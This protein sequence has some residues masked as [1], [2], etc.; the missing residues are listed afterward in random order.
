MR[1]IYTL[2]AMLFFV[3]FTFAQVNQIQ[4]IEEGPSAPLHKINRSFDSK[5]PTDTINLEDFFNAGQPSMGGINGMFGWMFGSCWWGVDSLA[6]NACAQGF[7]VTPGNTYNLEEVLIWAHSKYNVST[8][9]SSLIVTINAIDATQTYTNS[10]GSNTIDCPGT[11]LGSA[12]IPF[13][14]IDTGLSLAF[15]TASFSPSIPMTADYAIVVD[16]SDFYLNDDTVGFVAGASGSASNL[17]GIEYT[18]WKYHNTTSSNDFWTQ[19]SHVFTTSGSPSDRAIAFWPVVDD[20]TAGIDAH[21][22]VE[23][24]KMNQNRPNP[25]VDHTFID[26][27]LENSSKDVNITI[28]DA[29]GRVVFESNQGSQNHGQYSIKINTENFASGKYYYSLTADGNR[30]TKKMII[31]K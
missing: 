28:Y 23:G 26:Y 9:G 2:I 18:W 10:S 19:L 14:S 5:T 11:V 31:T 12:V 6:S 30:L 13:A 8:S 25:V 7:L 16:V 4:Q 29:N 21:N 27:V 3:S 17:M 24:L 1:K 15:T 20:G 22:F